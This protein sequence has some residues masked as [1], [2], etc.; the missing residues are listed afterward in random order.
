M[1]NDKKFTYNRILSI[2]GGGIRGVIPAILLDQIERRTEKPISDLFDLI[3]GTST[4]AILALGLVVPG[5]NNKP[6]YTARDLLNI[7]KDRGGEVFKKSLWRRI[8]LLDIFDEKYSNKGIEAVMKE[9]FD[10]IEL[11]DSLKDVLIT[12]Y[13]IENRKPYFFKSSKAENLTECRNHLMRDIAR[14]TSAAPTYFEPAETPALMCCEENKTRYLIDGG[15]VANNPAL[16]AY[17]EAM[18]SENPPDPDKDERFIFVSLGTGTSNT[19]I[20]YEKAKNWGKLGWV[21][22]VV[23]SLMDAA[24]DV[25][26]YQLRQILQPIPEQ[27]ENVSQ[28]SINYYRFNIKLTEAEEDMDAVD[29]E[30]IKALECEAVRILSRNSE[31]FKNMCGKLKNF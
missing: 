28:K 19:R 27:E 1:E 30:N 9:Y 10:D 3:A 6:K 11:R 4:G 16:C 29:D 31:S 20:P 2:D 12:S 21:R 24:N 5:E 15:I 26:D 23:S 18:N 17:A 14:A 8:P 22:P 25:V 13:D 7:Y